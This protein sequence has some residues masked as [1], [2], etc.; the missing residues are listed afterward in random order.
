[1]L[2]SNVLDT[3]REGVSLPTVG[4]FWRFGYYIR[5]VVQ[6]QRR[7]VYDLVGETVSVAVLLSIMYWI[8]RGGGGGGDVLEIWVLN[9]GFLCIIKF[10]L[11]STLAPKCLQ[12]YMISVQGVGETIS[13]VKY[14][15]LD[16]KGRRVWE[17]DS[18]ARVIPSEG[19]EK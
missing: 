9:T 13:V 5:C 11:T 12:M 15:V 8:P 10:K 2:L 1:M 7:K 3:N 14:N 6:L 18:P 17:G 4:T 19:I 16:T